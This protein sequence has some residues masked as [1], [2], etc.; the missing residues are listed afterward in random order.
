M[1]FLGMM[2]M[3]GTRIHFEPDLVLFAAAIALVA[4]MAALWMTTLPVGLYRRIGSALVMGLA[5]CGMHY[6]GMAAA[7]FSAYPADLL[8]HTTIATPG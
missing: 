4:S 2:A 8:E 1:H 6:T 7:H 5:I 3:T